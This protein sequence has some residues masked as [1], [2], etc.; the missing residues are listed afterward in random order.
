MIWIDTFRSVVAFLVLA[1][2][3]R[4]AGRI[5]IT[6][7]TFVHGPSVACSAC[8]EAR[9]TYFALFFMVR[10]GDLNHHAVIIA[11]MILI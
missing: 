3:V 7:A 10:Y 5:F 4:L 6:L 11:G 8:L 2:P 1:S 9:Y